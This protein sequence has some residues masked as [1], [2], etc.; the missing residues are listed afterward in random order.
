MSRWDCPNSRVGEKI[1]QAEP[2]LGRLRLR[3][4]CFGLEYNPALSGQVWSSIWQTVSHRSVT[5]S[6]F[7]S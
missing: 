6:R 1:P 3:N 4:L 7:R 2:S 5:A